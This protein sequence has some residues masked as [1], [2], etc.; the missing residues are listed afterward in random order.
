MRAQE[1]AD[2]QQAAG[3]GDAEATLG[4]RHVAWVRGVPERAKESLLDNLQKQSALSNSQALKGQSPSVTR[5]ILGTFLSTSVSSH[6][7]ET[8]CGSRKEKP[9]QAEKWRRRQPHSPWP[10]QAS[11]RS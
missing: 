6:A 9:G 1:A 3:G 4:Q 8:G 10:P 5:T 11:S 7:S 2:E